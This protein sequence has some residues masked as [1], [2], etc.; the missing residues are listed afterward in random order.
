MAKPKKT[1]PD[2]LLQRVI[3]QISRESRRLQAMQRAASQQ[4]C[5]SC[6]ASSDIGEG[7]RRFL[8]EAG[9]F[10]AGV[11]FGARKLLT[12]KMLHALSEGQLER[13]DQQLAEEKGAKWLPD[14]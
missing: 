10:V 4:R 12:E 8:I 11:A 9:K 1:N 6:G 2:V 14:A 7:P 13:L 3:N 5:A